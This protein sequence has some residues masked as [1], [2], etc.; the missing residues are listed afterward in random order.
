[1]SETKC[2]ILVRTGGEYSDFYHNNQT[3]FLSREEADQFLADANADFERYLPYCL[4][5][6]SDEE[7][8]LCEEWDK[9]N[10]D[11]QEETDYIKQNQAYND[12]YNWSIGK[13]KDRLTDLVQSA[14]CQLS[15]FERIELMA[16]D[17]ANPYTPLD[18]AEIEEVEV[19]PGTR[20][21]KL[22]N[23]AE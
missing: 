3:V 22:L 19:K 9:L 15:D 18:D 7:D 13:I 5:E 11:P 2:Y 12:R 8:E 14:E 1:M 16:N 17:F 4:E 21:Y 10:G 20:L 23:G 6:D